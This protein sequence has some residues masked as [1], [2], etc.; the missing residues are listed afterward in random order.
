MPF[1]MD[2][3]SR[4]GAVMMDDVIRAHQPGFRSHSPYDASPLRYWVNEYRGAGP[5]P[6]LALNTVIEGRGGR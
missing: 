4:D 3:H 2:T 6:R 1:Y 5:A